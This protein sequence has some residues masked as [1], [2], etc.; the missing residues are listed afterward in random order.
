MMIRYQKLAKMEPREGVAY[1]TT[2]VKQTLEQRNQLTKH[3]RRAVS[4]IADA[5]EGDDDML[6]WIRTPLKGYKTTHGTN[7]SA[8]DIITD[9]VNEAKGKTKHGLPKDYALA[10]IERWNKLFE[11]TDY[12]V[13]L[14][15]TFDPRPNQFNEIMELE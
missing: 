9:M 10:P 14:T 13:V 5:L 3:V 11:G 15:Q 2:Y 1:A 6:D 4:E 12:A 8:L 7:R